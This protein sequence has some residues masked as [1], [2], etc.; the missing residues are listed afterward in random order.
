MITNP[1]LYNA[2][3]TENT[4]WDATVGAYYFNINGIDGFMCNR[5]QTIDQHAADLLCQ[6]LGFANAEAGFNHGSPH[7][8]WFNKSKFFS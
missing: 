4:L 5:H 7:D 6:S 3:S 2:T 1:R 8:G